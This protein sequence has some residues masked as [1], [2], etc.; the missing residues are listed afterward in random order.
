MQAF[1]RKVASEWIDPDKA[2]IGA[3]SALIEAVGQRHAL[4]LSP[5]EWSPGEPLKLLFAGYVGTRNTG[6]DVR[7]EEILRQ[8]R[9]LLGPEQAELTVMTVN[10]A[11]SAGYFRGVAQ[12]V[13]PAVFPKFLFDEC[14]QHHGVISCEGSMFKSKFA[15]AL[16]TMMAGSLGMANA[17]GKLSVGYGAEAG[18]MT[19]D[20]ENF[21]RRQ[22]QDS[23]VLCRNEPSRGILSELGI[24]T[25]GGTDTAWTF[26]PAPDSRGAALLQ[27]A[28]WDGTQ[29]V[30]AVCPIN[31]FWWPV[32][33]DVIRAVRNQVAKRT[34]PYHYKSVY[35]HHQS[36]EA[37]AKN[38]RYLDAIAGAVNAF[39][40]ETPCFPI[41]VGMEQLDRKA[42]EALRPKLKETAPLFISDEWNM[43]DL[44]SVIRQCRWMVSSRFHAMVTSMP[45]GVVSAGITMD[46]RI[47]NLM[48]ARQTP[49]L[50]LEVDEPDLEEK[51]LGVL[52][53]IAQDEEE[54]RAGILSVVP[55]QIQMMGEMGIVFRKE[56]QRVY[57]DLEL[58]ELE[59]T[60]ESHL[61]PLSA[62]L[63]T[64]MEAK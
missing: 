35:Y 30:L 40:A 60:W 18:A 5:V 7:V 45:G 31:P 41:L 1:L 52:R 21:V 42:C 14:P 62:H 8:V 27:R 54:L 38:E 26:E 61:P 32:K 28:G 47:R 33:P 25:T 55:E 29:P 22:C 39:C 6:A 17:E 56:V 46:E 19:D 15:N 50:S 49:D 63:H 37:E 10:P 12:V 23:L 24:R 48:N 59:E 64:L 2:L 11:L 20:L 36:E 34:D 9:H 43:Y 58:P 57:P 53:R 3:T 13:L 51:L 16:S 44:V 4:G